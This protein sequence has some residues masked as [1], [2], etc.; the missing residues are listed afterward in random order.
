MS[1]AVPAFLTVLG[2]WGASPAPGGAGRGY[3]LEAEGAVLVGAGSGIAGRIAWA[4]REPGDLAAVLLPDLRPDHASDLWALGSWHAAEVRR[5]RRRG[6]L[7]VYAFA[8]PRER[9]RDLARPGIL[10]VRAFGPED[11]IHVAG[12]RLAFL[13]LD[14]A[15]PGVA[16]RAEAPGGRILGLVGLGR[17]S[18][19]LVRHLAGAD[20]LLVEVGGPRPVGDEGLDGGMTAAEAAALAREVGARRLWLAHLDPGD[21]PAAVAAEAAAGFPGAELGLEGRTYELG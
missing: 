4:L 17:P 9:W 11:Q 5:G 6:L 1:G 18:E 8:E 12:W 20:A 7:V 16:V 2:R 21:D 15:W 14:H 19:A 10:D 13:P 3:L